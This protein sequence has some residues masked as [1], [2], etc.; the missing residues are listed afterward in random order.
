MFIATGM[1]APRELAGRRVGN[2]S[3]YPIQQKS[4]IGKKADSQALSEGRVEREAYWDIT[5]AGVARRDIGALAGSA[6]D[7]LL[8]GW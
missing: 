6:V 4:G 7:F 1:H 5:P 3:R 2:S 8:T